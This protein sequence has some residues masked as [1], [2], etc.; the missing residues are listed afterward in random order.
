M[1]N[2]GTAASV[3]GTTKEIDHLYRGQ[4]FGE[5]A[6]LKHEPRMASALALGDLKCYTLTKTDFKTMALMNENFWRCVPQL[7]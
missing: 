2:D 3:R 5:R 7:L 4:Y 6:L 1:Q